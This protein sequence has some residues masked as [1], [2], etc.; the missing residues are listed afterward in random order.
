MLISYKTYPWINTSTGSPPVTGDEFL[1]VWYGTPPRLCMKKPTNPI[2]KHP[3]GFLFWVFILLIICKHTFGLDFLDEND[4]FIGIWI[5][6]F[7]LGIY[8]G[9]CISF[10]YYIN[11]YR[12]ERKWKQQ[13]I[14]D[15]K[16]NKLRHKYSE[17]VLNKF[18]FKEK[19]S[20]QKEDV[21]F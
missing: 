3:F 16:S 2:L 11:Y 18:E 17:S 12:K 9:S 7:I 1:Y 14:N 19:P 4:F 21:F 5:L 6:V 20:P 10:L 8:T 13:V 15:W